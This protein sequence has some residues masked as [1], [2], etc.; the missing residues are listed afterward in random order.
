MQ[1][2][3]KHNHPPSWT[4]EQENRQWVLRK[5]YERAKNTNNVK[6]VYNEFNNCYPV[7]AVTSIPRFHS[8]KRKLYEAAENANP[9][10]PKTCQGMHANFVKLIIYEFAFEAI[11]SNT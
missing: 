3:D 1:K 5:L 11:I 10:L 6:A 7:I 4:E 8:V 2:F 9:N